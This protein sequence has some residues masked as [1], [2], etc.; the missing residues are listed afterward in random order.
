VTLLLQIIELAYQPD[1]PPDYSTALELLIARIV[2]LAPME[3]VI[4]EGAQRAQIRPDGVSLD[5]DCVVLYFVSAPS[6]TTHVVLGNHNLGL[7]GLTY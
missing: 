3:T 7:G 4:G 6:T 1:I 2:H 5:T